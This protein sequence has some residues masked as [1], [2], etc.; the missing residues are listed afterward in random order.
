MLH[1]VVNAG[2][3]GEL[4]TFESSGVTFLMCMTESEAVKVTEAKERGSLWQ[5]FGGTGGGIG[6]I[7]T[8]HKSFGCASG[9]NIDR[10]LSPC[11]YTEVMDAYA[12]VAAASK[13]ANASAEHTLKIRFNTL[14]LDGV[15]DPFADEFCGERY[16][17]TSPPA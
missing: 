8:S 17:R 13:A 10:P 3:L 6:G 5:N 1:I 15:A 14:N 7:P 2:N 11:Y 4:D 9:L 16:A 12:Q